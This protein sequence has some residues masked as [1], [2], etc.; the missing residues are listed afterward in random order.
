VSR[1]PHSEGVDSSA[2][3]FLLAQAAVPASPPTPAVDPP[4]FI[5]PLLPFGPMP[6]GRPR[7]R[8][9]QDRVKL[10]ERFDRNGDGRLDG[11]E[12]DAARLARTG[13][14]PPRPF[15]GGPPGQTLAPAT[16]GLKVTPQQV[17]PASETDLY[18]TGV[19]RTLFLQ[20]ESDDWEQELA[21]FHHSDVD[22]P[23]TL[24]VDGRSYT[25]VGVHFRGQ[26][27]FMMV[28]AGHKR[29]LNVS[30]DFTDRKQALG[31]YRTL[32]LLNAHGD[33]SFLRAALYQ[34]IASQYLP[35]P[36][37][38]F[39]RLVINGES[40]G[41]YVNTQQFNKDLTQQLFGS[42]AGARWKVPGNPGADGGLNYLGEDLAEYR[43]RYEIKS[44][45]DPR[46]WAALVQL[47]R[48]LD[49]TPP[50]KLE[51]ALAPLLDI[52]GALKFLALENALINSDGYW[53]RASDYSLY[54]DPQGRFH[55][56]PHDTNET[57]QVPEG[58]G[59]GGGAAG[60]GVDLDPLAGADNPRRP[61]LSKLLAVPA[62]RARY[63][64]QLRQIA[65]RSMDWSKLE[66][67]IARY[68]K[69]IAAEVGRDTRKLHSTEAFQTS[70][71][72]DE[73]E[74]GP[75]GPRVRLSLKRFIEQRRA[76]LL[77]HPLLAGARAE[78]AGGPLDL[79][80]EAPLEFFPASALARDTG[81]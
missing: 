70:V 77:G 38:N 55:L 25:G 44:A 41:V 39:V 80:P 73:Q 16:P 47:T 7:Q 29:S 8:L 64:R 20:F 51:R 5:A 9:M 52:E 43:K 46:A 10:V 53:I 42:R 81:P 26:S 78:A 13:E 59:R 31:G 79:D 60:I 57:F 30:L 37:V 72:Q 40:W 1:L 63:L 76:F 21:A 36:R 12:R 71:T 4:G 48:V 56:I 62:L 32:N 27:S 69:L 58:P 22:V 2:L 75:R 33:P 74:S 68:R 11:A 67:V 49:Q 28:P 14:R 66:P 15:R 54:R 34:H 6:F 45:D 50:E 17:A 65:A 35:V 61:L 19:L 3:L 18:D 24:I 23:A